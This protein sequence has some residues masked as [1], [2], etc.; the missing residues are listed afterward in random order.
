MATGLRSGG[1][2][3]G[4]SKPHSATLVGAGR[5]LSLLQLA[6]QLLAVACF[7]TFLGYT[8]SVQ[9]RVVGKLLKQHLPAESCIVPKEIL[10]TR[11]ET[12][13]NSSCEHGRLKTNTLDLNRGAGGNNLV[14]GCA[15]RNWIGTLTLKYRLK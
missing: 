11:G 2:Y 15:G 4:D 12:I 9:L 3:T 14:G 10:T 13:G 8:I 1:M 5:A 6:V 7:E